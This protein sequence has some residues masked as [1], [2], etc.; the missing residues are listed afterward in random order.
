ML[1]RLETNIYTMKW[2]FAKEIL[3][4]SVEAS[5]N[6]FQFDEPTSVAEAKHSE[7]DVMAQTQEKSYFILV[8]AQN[9]RKSV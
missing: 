9:A 6:S 2:F 7:K 5:T 8:L 4:H 1:E 3:S